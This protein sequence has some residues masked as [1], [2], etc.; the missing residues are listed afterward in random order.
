MTKTGYILEGWYREEAFTT[1]WNFAV[2][3]VTGDIT[4]YAK[5]EELDSIEKVNAWL[6]MQTVNTAD[7]PLDLTVKIGLGDMTQAGSGWK[8]LLAALDD[9]V[10]YVNLNLAACTLTG[11]EFNPDNTDTSGGKAYVC[12]I[13]LPDTAES[14][15]DVNWSNPTFAHFANLKTAGGAEVTNIGA[16]AFEACTGLTGVNFPAVETIGNRAFWGCA[17]LT[18]VS[19]PAAET[20]GG[21]A[22]YGCTGLTSVSF[23]AETIGNYAFYGCTRLTSVSFPAAETIGND[24]FNGCTD[25]TSVSFPK[26]AECPSGNPFPYCSALT[27]ITL[28]PGGSGSGSLTFTVTEKGKALVNTG[29][30]LIAYLNASGDVT[31]TG[32]TNIGDYAFYGCT[33]LTGVSFPAA[34]TIGNGAFSGTGEGALTITLGPSAP[35]VGLYIFD[36]ATFSKPVTVKVPNGAIGYDAAWQ[37]AFKGGD[38]VT[39]SIE[40]EEAD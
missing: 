17:G 11:T 26:T 18:N 4:L 30:T 21:D 15:A 5:W 40:E 35:T 9:A 19:F 8:Q 14:I 32:I 31:M 1:L 33:G 39:L 37:T 7:G 2:D 38:S 34:Q 29:T 3:V 24:A 10:I 25:L 20:I 13:V 16:S 27:T 36:D 12:G 28:I 22:F 6:A 23:P